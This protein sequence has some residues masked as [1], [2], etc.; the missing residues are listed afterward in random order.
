MNFENI[1]FAFNTNFTL[2]IPLLILGIG[3][4]YF[5]YRFT[6]PV[7]SIFIKII[8]IILRSITLI[9][10]I[11]ILFEPTIT[12]NYSSKV[13]PKSLLL[14][15]NSSSIVNKDSVNRDNQTHAFISD[16]KNNVT[17]NIDYFT[18]GKEVT[19]IQINDDFKLLFDETITNFDN[20][21]NYFK[22]EDN[23]SSITLI[24]DGII[25][26]GTNSYSNFEKLNIPIFT[27]AIGDTLHP[28][29][30]SIKKVSY[31]KLIY[32]NKITEIKSIIRNTNLAGRKVFVTLYDASGVVGKEQIK[33]NGN[34][35][36]SVTFN[37]EPMEL[38]KQR[39]M[40]KISQLSEE[41]TYENNS[42]PF[43]LDVLNDKI[44]VLIIAGA[45]SSDLSILTQSLLK[46]KNIKLSK[47]I[48][49]TPN[50]FLDKKDNRLKLD[51]A[52]IFIMLDFPTVNTP[53]TLLSTVRSA[54][55][56]SH[57]P[58]F[59]FLSQS[60]NYVKLNYLSEQLPFTATKFS[61][62]KIL[63]QPEIKLYNNT[64]IKNTLGW[65]KLPPIYM[66][67]SELV[68]KSGT[69]IL[70]VGKSRNRPSQIPLLFS[71]NI[72]SS[73]SIVLNG[74]NFWKWN[75]QSDNSIDNLFNQFIADA[76]KWLYANN[77]QKR[78]FI[79]TSKD[80]YNSNESIDFI[81]NA[82][83]ESLSPRDD[84]TFDVK[85]TSNNFEKMIKLTST[86]NGKYEGTTNI[87]QPGNFNYSANISLPGEA[88]KIVNGKF[89]IAKTNLENINFVLNSNYLKFISN[90]TSGKS[91]DIK[92]YSN[93]FDEVNKL[94]E[95]KTKNK[96]VETKYSIWT[97]EW[98]LALI[99][100][101]L[102]FEWLIRKKKGML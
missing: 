89:T 23:I 78:I 63:V 56:S 47:I 55:A 87:S 102:A 49:I 77:N 50:K 42:Y 1:D 26:E 33:L 90:I 7:T 79:N 65:S 18:F 46:N 80:I 66:N 34:G 12:F 31:N 44:K 2:L 54:L 100:L 19:P 84:A 51:S 5:V 58:F 6:I 4:T 38:G 81:G 3:Y 85:I 68:L 69:T 71:S 97:N 37:Y 73:R 32:I 82:Y 74:F 67:T 43:I 96:I 57:K 94:S 88:T 8:L 20:I 99:I 75:L 35:I 70:A 91:F 76:I 83:D 98:I 30:I 62:Y 59:L 101:L 9:L 48:Q 22:S 95:R 61:K 45:P 64:L 16:F 21:T 13:Q 24:S 29:D 10:I 92:S 93:L 17:G 11:T 39:L 40:V 72:A 60:V 15:D 86:Q 52:D 27:I 25:N 28:S 41:E 14:I 53:A 36:N